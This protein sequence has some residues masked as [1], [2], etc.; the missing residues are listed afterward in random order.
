[1]L[2]TNNNNCCLIHPSQRLMIRDGQLD[3]L[4]VGGGQTMAIKFAENRCTL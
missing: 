4:V 2:F 3:I 1:M